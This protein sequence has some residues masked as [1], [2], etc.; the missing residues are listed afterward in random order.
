VFWVSEVKKLIERQMERRAAA[1]FYPS[2]K[3]H[4]LEYV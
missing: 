3:E 2:G 4:L 1:T